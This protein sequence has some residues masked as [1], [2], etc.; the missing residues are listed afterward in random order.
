MSNPQIMSLRILVHGIVG[1]VAEA[2][3]CRVTGQSW[4]SYS[5]R[6][7]PLLWHSHERRRYLLPFSTSFSR[8]SRP[9]GH[10]MV[11]LSMRAL[12][13]EEKRRDV[14]LR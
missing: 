6:K 4:L 14:S 8:S 11:V 5:K 10:L 9:H 1:D 12:F 7:T 3:S 13:E 2:P